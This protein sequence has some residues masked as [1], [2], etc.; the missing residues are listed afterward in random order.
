MQ[1]ILRTLLFLM[2]A[3]PLHV[4]GGNAY[5]DELSRVRENKPGTYYSYMEA[6]SNPLAVVH[7]DLPYYIKIGDEIGEFKNLE[8]ITFACWGTLP[9]SFFELRKL[10]EIKFNISPLSFPE[11]IANFDS[12]EC[13]VALSAILPKSAEKLVRLKVLDIN[14][15]EAGFEISRLTKLESLGMQIYDSVF[16]DQ[17]AAMHGQVS[18]IRFGLYDKARTLK[19][20]VEHLAS[21]PGLKSLDLH[22][23]LKDTA[24]SGLFNGPVHFPDLEKLVVEANPLN[25][26]IFG[27]C[28]NLTELHIT[29]ISYDYAIYSYEP[30]AL[31]PFDLTFGNRNLR[32]LEVDFGRFRS[33]V[34]EPLLQQLK[35]QK[36]L[37]ELVML[38]IDFDTAESST[39]NWLHALDKLT[40]LGFYSCDKVPINSILNQLTAI[41]PGMELRLIHSNSYDNIQVKASNNK[42]HALVLYYGSYI[43]ELHNVLPALRTITLDTEYLEL[44]LTDSIDTICYISRQE[45]EVGYLCS[46][47]WLTG[48][49]RAKF[50]VVEY[51]PILDLD[52]IPFYPKLNSWKPNETKEANY[53]FLNYHSTDTLTNLMRQEV[54]WYSSG[55]KLRTV[56]KYEAYMLEETWHENGMRATQ[57]ESE[58]SAKTNFEPLVRRALHWNEQGILVYYEYFSSGEKGQYLFYADGH[59]R[60]VKVTQ[61]GKCIEKK[62]YP[63][64]H[65]S[66]KAELK[67][68]RKKFPRTR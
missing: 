46:L 58:Q 10:K 49:S 47:N 17:V 27:Q 16:L 32:V 25:E 31:K 4:R 35:E 15:F 67:Q 7:L 57:I 53:Y 2:L 30:I 28:R 6:L 36:M 38:S 56:S 54:S 24:T 63:P 52:N 13:L 29:H 55:K 64:I 18:E 45:Y 61:N 1:L 19:K 5:N 26:L 66:D 34:I 51:Q 21:I 20:A 9:A 42:I 8:S 39:V 41:K 11:A 60:K 22:Y 37:E 40:V 43:D 50:Q 33:V 23:I 62:T 65:A 14:T 44:Q 68:K 48:N 59:L 12:L 3:A